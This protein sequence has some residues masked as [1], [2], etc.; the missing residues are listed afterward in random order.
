MGLHRLRQ[1]RVS[2]LTTMKDDDIAEHLAHTQD[3]QVSPER[4]AELWRV[5]ERL[6]RVTLSAAMETGTLLGDP[7]CF[8]KALV[9]CARGGDTHRRENDSDRG[10]TN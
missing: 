6:N 4:A 10:T 3:L 1:A 9:D 8:D 7:A 5:A 2:T